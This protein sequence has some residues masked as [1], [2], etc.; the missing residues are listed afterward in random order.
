MSTPADLN[1][2]NNVISHMLLKWFL[3]DALKSTVYD[4]LVVIA[5]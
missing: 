3:N 5:A 1:K 4:E 2:L